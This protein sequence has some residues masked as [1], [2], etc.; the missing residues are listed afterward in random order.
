MILREGGSCPRRCG[1]R[2]MRIAA[3]AGALVLALSAPASAAELFG[4]PLNPGTS[5]TLLCHIVNLQVSDI[6]VT[7]ELFDGLGAAAAVPFVGTLGHL[8]AVGVFVN[9]TPPA[10][11][12]C[13][14]SGNFSKAKVRATAQIWNATQGALAAVDAR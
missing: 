3:L 14:F 6:S 5:N 1:M 11:R 7:I 10:A 9:T 12:T 4:G 8:E 2:N 13:K